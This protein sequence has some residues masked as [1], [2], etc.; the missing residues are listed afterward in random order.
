MR[1]QAGDAD[2]QV[3]GQLLQQRGFFGAD[4]QH[5]GCVQ[6]Q[7]AKTAVLC[8]VARMLAQR[9]ADHP[10]KA[11]LQHALGPVGKVA[12]GAD[13]LHDHRLAGAHRNARRAP[14]IGIVGRPAQ[15]QVFQ[16]VLVVA[17]MGHGAD[18]FALV[19]Q[20]KPHPA[21][22]V[23][24]DVHRNLADGLQQCG[25]GRGAHQGFV[26][27]AQQALGTAHAR[28]LALGAQAFG[29]VGGQHLAG[30]AP[31]EADA[32]RRDLHIHEAAVLLDVAADDRRVALF[33]R[34]G[35]DVGLD[36]GAPV[37]GPQVQHR[38]GQQLGLGVAIV[39]F[40]RPVHGLQLQGFAVVHP[41]GVRVLVK[42][43]AVLLLGRM[44]LPRHMPQLHHGTQRL[45]QDL[46]VRHIAA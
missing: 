33:H 22:A 6:V 1:A 38:H 23:A 15:V 31:V 17:R 2:G 18:G 45:G 19:V 34:N 10:V 16:V 28:Q 8:V 5:V 41:H 44:Q 46:Q 27:C 4:L 40:H 26:A 39:A 30:R 35:A 7:Q 36:V 3:V 43:H 21:H 24:T 11:M 20:R 37:S 13:V 32:A 12:F 25:L 9:Q 14:A 29:H 42:Q